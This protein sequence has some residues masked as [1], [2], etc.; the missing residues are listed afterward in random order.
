[1]LRITKTS[2]KSKCHFKHV[3]VYLRKPVLKGK[4]SSFQSKK[5]NNSSP[6][7]AL[8][9]RRQEFD[10]V[11]VTWKPGAWKL[12]CHDP[13]MKVADIYSPMEVKH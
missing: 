10:M 8:T 7:F 13:I 6:R 5:E 4:S 2:F 12:L 11:K 3:K 9:Y 1:M